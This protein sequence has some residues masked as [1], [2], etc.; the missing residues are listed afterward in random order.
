MEKASAKPYYQYIESLLKSEDLCTMEL[1]LASEYF[2]HG[3][4]E[5]ALKSTQIL[6]MLKESGFYSI[7]LGRYY[8]LKALEAVFTGQ[9]TYILSY[10]RKSLNEALKE[11]DHNCVALTYMGL[12]NY[13][14]ISKNFKEAIAN[15]EKAILEFNEVDD[16]LGVAKV[17]VNIAYALYQLND[18]WSAT[19]VNEEAINLLQKLNN[20]AYLQYAYLNRAIAFKEEGIYNK[21]LENFNMAN[22][23]TKITGNTALINLTTVWITFCKIILKQKDIDLDE[24]YNAYRYLHEAGDIGYIL[25]CKTVKCIYSI[26]KGDKEEFLT[27]LMAF[28][29]VIPREVSLYQSDIISS[30]LTI[31][32]ALS[33]FKADMG[34]VYQFFDKSSLILSNSAS[35]DEFNQIARHMF[36]I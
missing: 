9:A 35:R 4:I 22:Q 18:Y 33:I 25:S 2:E 24:F 13:Y 30:L 26:Y 20:N 19:K 8:R 11:D 6:E 29:E 5:D 28:Q 34:I 32:R 3:K 10:Y 15:Y 12:G 7:R 36:P 21:A 16:K 27:E 31:L 14:A 23:I 17:K 1:R